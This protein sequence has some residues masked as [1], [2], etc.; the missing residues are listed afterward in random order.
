MK[1]YRVYKRETKHNIT[2]FVKTDGARYIPYGTLMGTLEAN[3][4]DSAADTVKVLTGNGLWTQA[5]FTPAQATKKEPAGH[6]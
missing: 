1:R 2:F 4:L 3:S 6:D 5:G